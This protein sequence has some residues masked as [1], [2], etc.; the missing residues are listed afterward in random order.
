[1]TAVV[2]ESMMSGAATM[3]FSCARSR[4]MMMNAGSGRVSRA[5]VSLRWDLRSVE[6][7]MIPFG[8]VG[9]G[10]CGAVKGVRSRRGI[11]GGVA[12]TCIV[13]V[14]FFSES[15]SSI[16]VVM[17]GFVSV[18]SRGFLYAFR[19]SMN[20]AKDPKAGVSSSDA[21]IE[22]GRGCRLKK[23]SAASGIAGLLR[24]G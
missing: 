4:Y 23:K 2:G 16:V 22:R 14:V 7:T 13:L 21:A 19:V 15:I 5:C 18:S 20:P 8:E 3:S 12:G 9:F 24:L 1:M 6:L 10:T 11:S 17:V